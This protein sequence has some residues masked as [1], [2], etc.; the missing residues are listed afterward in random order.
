MATA[1]K[2]VTKT[3]IKTATKPKPKRAAP[4][5]AP[6][7]TVPPQVDDELGA[8]W[9]AF[10]SVSDPEAREQLILHYAPL[11]KYVASRVATGLPSSV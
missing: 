1:K 2:T 9:H 3:A 5:S 10:K 7:V 8:K 6:S 4:V 11:V